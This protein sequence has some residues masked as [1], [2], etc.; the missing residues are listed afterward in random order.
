MFNVTISSEY[1][2]HTNGSKSLIWEQLKVCLILFM[3]T[4]GL[5]APQSAVD[6]NIKEWNHINR[7]NILFLFVFAS[8]PHSWTF[9]FWCCCDPIDY[10][11]ICEKCI[12]RHVLTNLITGKILMISASAP[13]GCQQKII[14]ENRTCKYLTLQ[15]TPIIAAGT[16][17]RYCILGGKTIGPIV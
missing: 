3:Y 11:P 5:H 15:E 1:I 12:C 13:P 10:F 14:L 4:K 17:L 2:L 8:L 6:R 7:T 9:G 16:T